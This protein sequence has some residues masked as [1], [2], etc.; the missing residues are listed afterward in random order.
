M[1]FNRVMDYLAFVAVN[2]ANGD[3][4]LQLLVVILLPLLAATETAN[5]LTVLGVW[6]GSDCS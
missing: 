4:S 5:Q 1:L 6:A 3:H 2:I